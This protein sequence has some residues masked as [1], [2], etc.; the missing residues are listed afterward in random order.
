MKQTYT[1][2]QLEKLYFMRDWSNFICD[3]IA[4]CGYKSFDSWHVKVDENY[5]SKYFNGFVEGFN[6][7]NESSKDFPR[8]KFNELNHRLK[9]KFGKTL[10]DMDKKQERKIASVLKRHKV[11]NEDEFRMVQSHIENIWDN[12]QK[13][14][15]YETLQELNYQFEISK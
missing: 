10:Y 8:N 7:I 15:E 12:S 5:Q 1:R 4:E 6:D 13:K 2:Q 9:E 14:Q 3:F 11:R